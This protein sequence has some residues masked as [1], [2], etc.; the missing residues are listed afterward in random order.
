PTQRQL[1][2]VVRASSVLCG[3]FMLIVAWLFQF[4]GAGAVNIN[5]IVAGI[6]DMPLFII[7]IVYGLLWRR[8]NWQGALAGFLVG[9]MGSAACYG[10]FPLDYAKQVAPIVSSVVAL[11]VTP[12]VALLTPPPAENSQGAQIVRALRAG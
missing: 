3:A 7:T 4:V 5:L 10:L 9:G 1:L 8:V 11:I 2:R 12:I 6:L